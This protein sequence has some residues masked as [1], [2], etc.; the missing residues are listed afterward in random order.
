[1]NAQ[2]PE[3]DWAQGFG[4][5][6]K[7]YARGIA[8]DHEGNVLCTGSFMGETD[9]DP[10]PGKHPLTTPHHFGSFVQ[11]LSPQ[12]KL[13][14]A[15]GM[16][17]VSWGHGFGI[18]ADSANNVIHSGSY[19]GTADFDTSKNSG[20]RA[21]TTAFVRK[22]SSDG[23]EIWRKSFAN[24]GSSYSRFCLADDE[25]NIYVSGGFVKSIDLDPGP[26]E[27]W[28]ESKGGYDGFMVKLDS[29]GNYL[30]GI[31]LSGAGDDVFYEMEIDGDKLALAGNFEYDGQLESTD[32]QINLN[33]LGS[34][35]AFVFLFNR[36]GELQWHK[37]F[38]G[39]SF[40]QA[41]GLDFDS[42]GNVLVAGCFMKTGDFD[43]G[44]GVHILS[45]QEHRNRWVETQDIYV[46]KLD[47]LGEFQWA[48]GIGGVHNDNG[49]CV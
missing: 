20:K 6:E 4:G 37:Q 38:G 34:S 13:L 11:K 3:L 24:K 21:S 17:G 35:D 2:P 49:F 40:D 30:W 9:L 32:K 8:I 14:W 1:M 12:G 42:N 31:T 39:K 48:K 26:N 44:A 25:G 7:D 19:Q 47:S 15:K 29:D 23:N 43:P 10:G 22:L 46:L 36:E 16:D 33:S 27:V 41:Q 5:K 18:C 28:K 45:T